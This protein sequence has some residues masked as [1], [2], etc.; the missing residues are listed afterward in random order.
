[1]T[2]RIRKPPPAEVRVVVDGTIDVNVHVNLDLHDYP[3]ET[4]LS[5]LLKGLEERLMSKLSDKIAA[6]GA[7]IDKTTDRVTKDVEALTAK[8]AELQ[9]TVDAGDGTPED[10]AALD[11]AIA[12][13]AMIDPTKP[14]T[15]PDENP[16][17]TPDQ[18]PA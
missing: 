4:S 18:P 9:A 16:P 1:M 8:I 3:Y 14:D 12:K 6:L 5:A 2:V 7:A 13:L 17:V 11:E 15:I 10:E